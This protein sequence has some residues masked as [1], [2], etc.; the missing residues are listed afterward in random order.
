VSYIATRCLKGIKKVAKPAHAALMAWISMQMPEIETNGHT[1]PSMQAVGG[2][3]TSPQRDGS[4]PTGGQ[5]ALRASPDHSQV[6][7]ARGLMEGHSCLS[8]YGPVQ[9]VADRCLL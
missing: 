5:P 6:K 8:C 4:V 9:P 7:D 2:F 3:G 1:L